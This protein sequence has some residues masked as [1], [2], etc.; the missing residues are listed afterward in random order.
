MLTINY[1]SQFKKDYKLAIKR[2]LN[3]TELEK[4]INE[5]NIDV[6]IIDKNP[7]EVIK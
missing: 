7:I 2:G 4:V 5:L 1:Q 6:E 3:V